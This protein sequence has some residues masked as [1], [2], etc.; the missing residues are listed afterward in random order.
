[1]RPE[2]YWA[3]TEHL[4]DPGE[5]YLGVDPWVA[6]HPRLFAMLYLVGASLRQAGGGGL[7]VPRAA[8]SRRRRQ[9]PRARARGGHQHRGREPA[10]V[11]GVFG[12]EL[13]ARGGWGW[14][15]NSSF[16]HLDTRGASYYWTDP[17]GPGKRQRNRE[18]KPTQRARGGA[19][20]TA[21]SVHLGPPTASTTSPPWPI[22]ARA[23]VSGRRGRA[24]PRWPAPPP[25][26]RGSPGASWARC[27]CRGRAAGDAAPAWVERA[28]SSS[29]TSGPRRRGGRWGFLSSPGGVRVATGGAID[30]ASA[31]RVVCSTSRRRIRV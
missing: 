10:S 19:D 29:V 2:A 31:P 9:Q 18:R 30:A 17:S 24:A 15:P 5:G 7:G 13:R 16:V 12:S 25:A 20:P 23:D 4:Y 27:G 8:A 11:I 1:M 28:C 6:Y 14:Y 3:L 26:T 21:H 22:L